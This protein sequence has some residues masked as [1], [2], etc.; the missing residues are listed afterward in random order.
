MQL[1][2]CL[3]Y[4]T[5]IR[6]NL[7]TRDRELRLEL[8]PRDLTVD[9]TLRRAHRKVRCPILSTL[10]YLSGIEREGGCNRNRPSHRDEDD[11]DDRN[12]MGQVP[13]LARD[14]DD[15]LSERKILKENILYIF[16]KN[17]I[18]ERKS[19]AYLMMMMMILGGVR[20]I[21][22]GAELENV[23]ERRNEEQ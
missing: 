6:T 18:R 11:E 4:V 17:E 12:K 9:W 22:A 20:R 7:D 10:P 19:F 1:I 21:V 13:E 14:D 3:T 5:A 15:A 8:G 2:L 16:L 23:R